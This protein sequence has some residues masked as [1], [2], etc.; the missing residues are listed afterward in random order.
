MCRCRP[1]HLLSPLSSLTPFFFNGLQ[2]GGAL[3]GPWWNIR[4]RNPIRAFK[5][6]E[7]GEPY[8]MYA[9]QS[10]VVYF[11]CRLGRCHSG[12][13][14]ARP[15]GSPGRHWRRR[16]GLSG[17]RRRRPAARRGVS[18]PGGCGPAARGVWGAAGLRRGVLQ[19]PVS[20]LGTPSLA[21]LVRMQSA[22]HAWEYGE[23][24]TPSGKKRTPSLPC[25]QG[26]AFFL[27]PAP[28][29]ISP[30]PQVVSPAAADKVTM[31]AIASTPPRET[32]CAP[33]SSPVK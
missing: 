18:S 11:S 26:R 10:L 27:S 32:S 19:A 8:A 21:P 22:L 29:C 31:P 28:R 13:A 2:S 14:A 25:R 33:A 6:K 9:L 3:L 12:S 17:S 1:T 5:E 7:G 16:A 4:P 15:R 30:R 24:S 23:R 20:P